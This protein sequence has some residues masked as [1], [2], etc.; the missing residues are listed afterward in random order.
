MFTDHDGVFDHKN[1]SYSLSQLLSK[2][3]YIQ[4]ISG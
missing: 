3:Y 4:Q 2:R 1:T